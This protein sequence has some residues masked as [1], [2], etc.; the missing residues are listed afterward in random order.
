[1]ATSGHISLSISRI[2]ILKEWSI[3]YFNKNGL[4][5][6]PFKN[7]YSPDSIHLKHALT[8]HGGSPCKGSSSPGVEVVRWHCAHERHLEVSVGVDSTCIQH[9]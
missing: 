6:L 4:M 1:M 9:V 3:H 8:D 5:P 2:V 7:V